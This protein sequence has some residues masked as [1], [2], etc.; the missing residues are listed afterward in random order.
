L[1]GARGEADAIAAIHRTTPLTGDGATVEAVARALDG[2]AVAHLATHGRVNQDNP[3]FSALRFADGP[4]MVHDLHTVGR[5]PHTV[6]LAA[7]DVG[8]PVVRAGDELLGL[9]AALLAQGTG[10]LVAPVIS[11]LDVETAPLMVA[12]HRLLAAGR[13]AAV[14]LA[15]AQQ[16]L[17]GRHPTGLA[18]VAPFVC[19]GAGF[20]APNIIR[21]KLLTGHAIG[22]G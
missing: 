7:C 16:D 8:R 21:P 14:A 1:A 6:V 12:F 15:C 9:S 19:V 5:A 4:L 11:V 18:E 20:T 17:A 22:N 2:A 3:L 13:P 10:Q